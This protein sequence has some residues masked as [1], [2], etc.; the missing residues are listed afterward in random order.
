MPPPGE[1]RPDP[2]EGTNRIDDL[3]KPKVGK[4]TKGK[5]YVEYAF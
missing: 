1:Y 2:T 4:L 5:L 3:P